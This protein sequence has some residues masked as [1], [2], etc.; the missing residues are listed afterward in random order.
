MSIS[1]LPSPKC[2]H[3]GVPLT[4]LA[5][6]QAADADADVIVRHARPRFL[7]IPG[8][9]GQISMP[10]DPNFMCTGLVTFALFFGSMKNTLTAPAFAAGFLACALA[11]TPRPTI[12][13]TT[14][15]TSCLLNVISDLLFA[16]TF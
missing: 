15:R 8:G 12:I 3:D 1:D 14:G 16:V 2:T 7:H 10:D 6:G 4:M 11:Y 5:G 9:T 13:P